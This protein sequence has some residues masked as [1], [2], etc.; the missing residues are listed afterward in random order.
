MP[1]NLVD[2]R[3]VESL[4]ALVA[5]QDFEVR[6]DSPRIAKPPGLLTADRADV[7]GRLDPGFLDGP[8]F[9][10]GEGLLQVG[11]IREGI[12]GR[13]AQPSQLLTGR[14][15]IEATLQVVQSGL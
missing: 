11:E 12:H 8:D 10:F 5:L 1:D 15:E 6:A 7:Q 9:A 3:L 4:V 14:G 13:N 2:A